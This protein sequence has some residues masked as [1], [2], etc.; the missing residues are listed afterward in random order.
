MPEH[1]LQFPENSDQVTAA[2]YFAVEWLDQVTNPLGRNPRGVLCGKLRGG[3]DLTQKRAELCYVL[4]QQG[5]G[6]LLEGDTR[7]GIR[8]ARLSHAQLLLQRPTKAPKLCGS[9]QHL[10][11]ATRAAALQASHQPA[12]P[13]AVASQSSSS[14]GRA[15]TRPGPPR[16]APRLS[17]RRTCADASA[18]SS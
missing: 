18:S 13:P 3:M 2:S 9:L 11:I 8:T 16:H 12:P 14:F 5:A 6:D 17:S 10:V 1:V 15:A 7:R 4:R